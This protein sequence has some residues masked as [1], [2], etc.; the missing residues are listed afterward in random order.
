MEL[1]DIK[2]EKNDNRL[3]PEDLSDSFLASNNINDYSLLIGVHN[4]SIFL[5]IY[6]IK[7]LFLNFYFKGNNTNNN[8]NNKYGFLKLKDY[9]NLNGRNLIDKRIPFYE[10]DFGGLYTYDK[11]QIIFIAIIDIFTQYGYISLILL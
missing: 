6:Y 8:D 5:F 7:I 3:I 2:Q 10:K 11:N 4:S 9:L 1:S